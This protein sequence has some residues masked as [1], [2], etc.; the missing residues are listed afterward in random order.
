MDT[1]LRDLIDVK[2]TAPLT[3]AATMRNVLDHYQ[4]N[5]SVSPDL[6]R[7]VA[8]LEGW[9]S[10]ALPVRD[11]LTNDQVSP[12]G[13]M[14]L[15]INTLIR[16]LPTYA[17]IPL[18]LAIHG[19]QGDLLHYGLIAL[20]VNDEAGGGVPNRTHPALF[21]NS[22]AALCEIFDVPAISVKIGR[23]AMILRAYEG[24]WIGDE[25]ALALT[26]STLRQDEFGIPLSED[27]LRD[28][29]Q[30]A[31]RY[32]GLIAPEA[33]A[34]YD[35]RM[36][37]LADLV[38]SQLRG[39]GL[40]HDSYVMLAAML[41]VREAAASDPRGIFHSFTSFAMRYAGHLGSDVDRVGQALDWSDAHVDEAM[42][43]LAGYEGRGVEDDHAEQALGAVLNHIHC[44]ED[45]LT[46]LRAMN[47]NNRHRNALWEGTVRV[48]AA[49]PDDKLPASAV[50]AKVYDEINRR[51]MDGAM[52]AT[53]VGGQ[54]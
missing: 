8:E 50:P 47:A 20:N 27:Q 3:V 43:A 2:A 11:T 28:A 32:A 52:V 9:S 1:E 53:P 17:E 5:G 25:Q 49:Q 19:A 6:V 38:S 39:Y 44:E 29:L 13:F 31:I 16:V 34:C 51:R 48:M 36:S 12:Q 37:T 30:T 35:W 33:L 46:A 4:A 42:G 24:A 40:R 7:E 54:R 18:N 15:M 22:A 41:A 45:L 21:N 10:R 14:A 23:A 26:Y